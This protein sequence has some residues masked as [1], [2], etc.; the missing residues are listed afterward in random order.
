MI[1][2]NVLLSVSLLLNAAALQLRPITTFLPLALV[3]GVSMAKEALEDFR[4]FQADRE[5]NKRGVL[6]FNPITNAWERK[7][8]RD[9]LVSW[10]LIAS[11]PPAD[12]HILSISTTDLPLFSILPLRCYCV[13]S[14]C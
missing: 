12:N 5:V 14:R 4:R 8:W 10:G 13:G 3:L 1:Q 9:I 2:L 6:V 11:A 7:Q